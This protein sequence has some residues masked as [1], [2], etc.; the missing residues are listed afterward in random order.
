MVNELNFLGRG[1]AYNSEEKNTSAYMI[2]NDVLLLIDCGETVFKKIISMNLLEGIKEIHILITHMHSDHIGSLGSFV[3]F[4]RWKYNIVS[5][6]YFNECD[7]LSEYLELVGIKEGKSF[8]RHDAE[9]KRIDSM[10]VVISSVITKHVDSLN[11]YSYNLIF[12][13]GN[14]IFYSG[15]TKETNLDITPFLKSGNIIYHDTCLS[16]DKGCPHTS[17][18]TFETYTRR[19]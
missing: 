7:S 5:N 8:K 1:S 15:D 10:G 4:C 9:N 18:R 12:D 3:G 6:I 19:V 2:K 14:D 13:E 16:E 11:S 17:L